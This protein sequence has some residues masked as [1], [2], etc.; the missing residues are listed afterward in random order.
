MYI[1]VFYVTHRLIVTMPYNSGII[2]CALQK[3]KW[4]HAEH[5]CGVTDGC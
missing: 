4:V 3:K 2:M 5:G 1:P